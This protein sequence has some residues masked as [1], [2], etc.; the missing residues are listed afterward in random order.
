[1]YNSQPS[2]PGMYSSGAGTPSAPPTGTPG[3]MYNSGTPMYSPGYGAATPLSS[4]SAAMYPGQHPPQQQQQPNPRQLLSRDS[5]I[6]MGS[7]AG[8]CANAT[9]IVELSISGRN[10]RDMDYFSKSDPMVAVFVQ[11]FGSKQWREFARTEMVQN[12]L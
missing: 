4:H 7:E 2:T 5:M 8:S 12:N 6:S 10:L 11:P 3:S 1:M 9:S